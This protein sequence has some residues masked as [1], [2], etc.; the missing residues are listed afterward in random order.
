MKNLTGSTLTK[1]AREH[2]LKHLAKTL[3]QVGMAARLQHI[4]ARHV[5]RYVSVQQA[6]GVS[7]RTLQNRLSHIRSE[8]RAI[9]RDKL[10]DSDR[11]GCAH[12][13]VDGA[14]RAGTHAALS[15]EQYD[16]AL[17]Q[18]RPLHERARSIRA[19]QPA[20]SCSARWGCGSEKRSRPSTA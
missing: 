1:R 5:E 15:L 17:E 3:R 8:L 11:L 9:G 7:R 16:R 18:A 6:A 12:L 13:R 2:S 14:S 19:L 4:T 10:A 20:C